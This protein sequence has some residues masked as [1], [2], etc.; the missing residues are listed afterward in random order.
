MKKTCDYCGGS[1]QIHFFAGVSRFFLSCEECPACA[2]FGYELPAEENSAEKETP[3]LKKK[4][5]RK[6]SQ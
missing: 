1:G 5:P 6:R 3:L 2:G 4:S